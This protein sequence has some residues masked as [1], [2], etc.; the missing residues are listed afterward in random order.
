MGKYP[1]H[2]KTEWIHAKNGHQTGYTNTKKNK[3]HQLERPS[4]SQQQQ[5]QQMDI[6]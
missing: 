1:S 3:T 5:Q 2:S 6:L 4:A